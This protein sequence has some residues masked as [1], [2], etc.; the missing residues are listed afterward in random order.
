MAATLG[1]RKSTRKLAS[2]RKKKT[3]SIGF[4]AG[5]CG[6]TLDDFCGVHKVTHEGQAYWSGVKPGWFVQAVDDDT[7]T[8]TTVK[9]MLKQAVKSKKP[10]NITFRL[11]AN[12][13][14]P[15]RM[16]RRQ[17]AA[18]IDATGMQGCA[19]GASYLAG[20]GNYRAT[21][22]TGLTTGLDYEEKEWAEDNPR[23][24]LKRKLSEEFL[25]APLETGGLIHLDDLT[26]ALKRMEVLLDDKQIKKFVADMMKGNQQLPV[27]EFLRVVGATVEMV[28]VDRHDKEGEWMNVNL[29]VKTALES[30]K[31]KN[32]F[33]N[34][35]MSEIENM[36]R[37]LGL[38]DMKARQIERKFR[39][40]DLNKD[41]FIDVDELHTALTSDEMGGGVTKEKVKKMISDMT[42][43]KDKIQLQD[44]RAVMVIASRKLPEESIDFIF[45]IVM[46]SMRR[47][48]S[49]NLEH[50]AKALIHMDSSG[51][52]M[53]PSMIKM[54]DRVNKKF[55]EIDTNEDGFLDNEEITMA[56]DVLGYNWTRDKVSE[57]IQAIDR[58][59]N[60][61]IDT[62]EF[63]SALMGALA[64]NP[65]QSI[66]DAL[67]ATIDQL[68]RK[69]KVASLVEKGIA[70][71]K[72]K[73]QVRGRD[74]VRD[75]LLIDFSECFMNANTS[76]TGDLSLI[77]FGKL[78]ANLK[79]DYTFDNI[80]WAF[81]K[82]HNPKTNACDFDTL[83]KIVKAAYVKNSKLD[84]AGV[85]EKAFEN[86]EALVVESDDEEDAEDNKDQEAAEP[87][88][89][90]EAEPE[91]AKEAEADPAVDALSTTAQG[92]P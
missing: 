62:H 8:T 92:G 36:R 66:D 10:F 44:F 33:H 72:A 16:T 21:Q 6:F 91:P 54:M 35:F 14:P 24:R 55:K 9:V 38:M 47:R 77:E 1:R 4:K 2:P 29:V 46:K 5:K 53:S 20:E 80:E 60:G 73:K 74:F 41:G 3:R 79:L 57:F 70:L 61:L 27:K 48:R 82:V 64:V 18:T 68:E 42:G 25:K 13:V 7:V 87:E 19:P 39:K 31:A 75:K 49:L 83:H 37:D 26:A 51:N 30:W 65:K 23:N 11:P 28:N 59:G 78:C 71:K 85:V 84:L 50:Q 67:R 40:L 81:N 90:K 12:Y 15:Q 69:A 52:L 22:W 43:G 58:D 63:K 86:A 89:A 17:R 32:N 45:Q 76:Q 56:L 88:P 34:Q